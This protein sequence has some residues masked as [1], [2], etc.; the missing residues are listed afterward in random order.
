[1][2]HPHDLIGHCASCQAPI[3]RDHPYAWCSKCGTPLPEDLQATLRPTPP[4]PV[5]RPPTGPRVHFQI[6]RSGYSA[7]EDL[8]AEAARFATRMGRER[9]INISHSEDDNEGVVTVWYW[10]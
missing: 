10:T 7:W 3:H 1:M 2:P 6:F 4:P 9:V 8:F 5:E